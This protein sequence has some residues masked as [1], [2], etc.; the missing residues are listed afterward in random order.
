M[1]AA[2]VALIALT[3][4]RGFA[5]L[6][7]ELAARIDARAAD[8]AGGGVA[9]GVVEIDSALLRGS[10]RSLY[11]WHGAR[12]RLQL[13][14]DLGDKVLDCAADGTAWI[15][16]LP[17][18]GPSVRRSW[19]ERARDPLRFFAMTLLERAT[20]LRSG[21]VRGARRRD[22]GRWELDVRPA[23]RSGSLRV[24][25]D[26]QGRWL[27]RKYGFRGARWTERPDGVGAR[28]FRLRIVDTTVQP[29]G[30]PTAEAFAPLEP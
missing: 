6:S 15:G 19:S 26:E 8:D 3:A 28:G 5:P 13:W 16:R 2:S 10:F 18:D 14:P 30:P 17:G 22:A 25:V 9:E 27:E 1:R 23:S 29:G 24:V 20:P 4:C 12:V 11:A 21:R 7:P